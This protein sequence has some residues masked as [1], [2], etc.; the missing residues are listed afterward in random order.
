MYSVPCYCGEVVR[1]GEETRWKEIKLAPVVATRL[2]VLAAAY[3]AAWA[4][5]LNGYESGTAA[6]DSASAEEA[7][8]ASMS[9]PVFILGSGEVDAERAGL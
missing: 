7:I 9:S 3:L 4:A 5:L 1:V 8:D 2:P 6:A